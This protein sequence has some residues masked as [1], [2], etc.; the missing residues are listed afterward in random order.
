VSVFSR[1]GLDPITTQLAGSWCKPHWLCDHDRVYGKE[2]TWWRIPAE[3][4]AEALDDATRLAILD[5][6][7]A[8][9]TIVTDGEVRRQ[10]FSGHFYAWGGIDSEEPGE[11]TNFANDVTGYLTMKQRP[12]PAP[13]PA[14]D[15]DTPPAKPR[16]EQP[17]VVGP[18]TWHEPLLGNDVRFSKATANAPVKVTIIGPCT[19]ALRLV[20]EHYGTL[21]AVA[22]ALAD[23]INAEAKALVALGADVIQIDEPEV[24]FRYSQVAPFAVEA[25]DRALHGLADM[26][27]P[28]VVHMCYGYSKNIAEK[29]ATPVYE[30][31]MQ[32]LASTTVGAL[33]LEWEQPSH[34]AALL[35]A[36]GDKDIVLGVLN[37]DTEAQV[38]SVDHIVARARA[39]AAVIGHDRLHLGPDC[40]MWFLPRSTATAKITAMATA[41]AQLRA[42]A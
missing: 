23:V 2:G 28:T 25:I 7:R 3:H 22:I 35:A 39:A 30:Q 42:S 26:G 20:D 18:L 12:A 24:H 34:D 36:A 32:L 31:A 37:L 40:G 4:R 10:T 17:R 21:A 19:L 15:T 13:G 8:G 27:V 6:E 11:V 29:R 5:Q 33:S 38:E 1:L 14:A 9:L 41:A 16:F